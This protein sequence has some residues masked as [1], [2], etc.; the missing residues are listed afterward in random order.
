MDVNFGFNEFVGFILVGSEGSDATA[1]VVES[2]KPIG[3]RFPD[4]GDL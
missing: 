1:R 3:S 2:G 4:C